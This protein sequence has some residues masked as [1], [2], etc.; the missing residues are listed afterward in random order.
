MKAP[1]GYQRRL[2]LGAA[3]VTV[4]A[5]AGVFLISGWLSSEEEALPDGTAEALV[6]APSLALDMVPAGNTYDAETNSMAL[7]Q[8]DYC[9]ETAAPGNN[10]AHMHPA[11]LVITNVEDLVGWQARLNY[12]G[13]Q[14]RPLS[15]NFTPFSDGERGQNIS[16][17]NLP[18]D[19]ATGVH[20]DLTSATDIPPFAIGPQTALIGSVY[21]GEQSFAVSVDTPAKAVPDDSS[22]S[23]PDGGVVAQI[24][25]QMHANRAGDVWYMD[26]DDDSPNE[27]GSSVI[28][29]TS[30][31]TSSI[32]LLEATLGD[33]FH[34]EGAPCP[35]LAG[36]PTV[37]PG[38]IPPP[39]EA[40]GGTIEVP[41]DWTPPPE[42]TPPPPTHITI[43]GQQV[44]LAPGMTFGRVVATGDGIPEPGATPPPTPAYREVWQVAY[45]S[46]PGEIGYSK[47]T[48]DE[49][50]NI[51]T[52]AIRPEDQ[53][54][55]QPIL[56][57]LTQS[58]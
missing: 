54:E 35:L 28:I 48:F 17:L 12:E 18:L 44:P 21:V 13:A 32:V 46:N 7:G 41:A 1:T 51:L 26:V 25:L 9:L 58:Q 34:G 57:A 40:E 30:S 5:I 50:F 33:G 24:M 8:A 52:E 47:L 11:H 38:L 56:D 15:V 55:F 20:R 6:Q 53:G 45:D 14:M 36:V 23:A 43:R 19:S 27:P 42:V 3:A 39:P 31:G 37:D 29:F 22:Y 4:P 16:F 10:D 49:N 2:L